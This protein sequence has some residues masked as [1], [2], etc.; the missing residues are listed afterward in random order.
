MTA[1]L[2]YESRT[3]SNGPGRDRSPCRGT[4]LPRS[5]SGYPPLKPNTVELTVN[6]WQVSWLFHPLSLRERVGRGVVTSQIDP[7]D[8]A[9][10]HAQ[11]PSPRPS[12]ARGE[13]DRNSFGT[14]RYC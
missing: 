7:S 3:H 6:Q 4:T 9:I 2:I 13:G 5:L 11:P 1:S 14:V 10:G 12:P 8:K